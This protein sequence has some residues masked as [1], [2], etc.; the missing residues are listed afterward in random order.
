[1]KTLLNAS[2]DAGYH[3]V[4]WDGKDEYGKQVQSG[5]YFFKLRDKNGKF[6]DTKK[7]IL[8]K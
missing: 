4:N 6:T 1:M 8:M 7:M 2:V 3:S 5:I